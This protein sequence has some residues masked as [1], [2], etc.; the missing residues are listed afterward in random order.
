V[1]TAVIKDKHLRLDQKKIDRVREI[2]GTKTETEAI[3]KALD[4]LIQRNGIPQFKWAGALK[5]LSKKYSSVQLQHEINDLR[6]KG[7]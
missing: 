7:R 5:K 6:V 1:S 2:L 3:E 4:M